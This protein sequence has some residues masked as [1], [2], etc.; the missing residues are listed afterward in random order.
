[1]GVQGWHP[2]QIKAAIRMRGKTCVQLSTDAGYCRYAV[3][4][5]LSK[6]WPKIEAMIAAFIGTK[7]QLIWPARYDTS[8][9]PLSGRQVAAR[10]HISRAPYPTKRQK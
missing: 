1:M 2:E 9:A 7:P 10:R 4:V 8:G 6:P 3:H 5:A